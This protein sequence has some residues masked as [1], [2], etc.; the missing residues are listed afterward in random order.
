[1]QIVVY[2]LLDRGRQSARMEDGFS[3]TGDVF[4][5]NLISDEPEHASAVAR[6]LWRT[7]KHGHHTP[8]GSSQPPCTAWYR[9]VPP[10][11]KVRPG[12]REP[13]LGGTYRCNGVSGCR[14]MENSPLLALIRLYSP[15]SG[16]VMAR[17]RQGCA[18]SEGR[19]HGAHGVHPL[20]CRVACRA[21]RTR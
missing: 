10:F 11:R 6:R 21:A 8:P 14:R 19:L 20:G 4:F 9:F 18:E 13:P 12:R 7:R 15:F 1:M 16:E 5:D 2:I 17:M 3:R